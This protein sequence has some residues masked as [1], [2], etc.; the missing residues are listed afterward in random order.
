MKC[1]DIN[2]NT[3]MFKVGMLVHKLVDLVSRLSI[4]TKIVYQHKFSNL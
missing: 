3:L 1:V 2:L 4:Q